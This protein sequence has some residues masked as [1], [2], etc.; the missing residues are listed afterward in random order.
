M[1]RRTKLRQAFAFNIFVVERLGTKSVSLRHTVPG[2][3]AQN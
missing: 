2:Y 3:L 1:T